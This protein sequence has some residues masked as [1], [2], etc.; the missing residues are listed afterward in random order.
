C[1]GLGKP[2]ASGGSLLRQAARLADRPE[3][4]LEAVDLSGAQMATQML[5][6]P[7]LDYRRR[8]TGKTASWAGAGVA[9]GRRMLATLSGSGR[10]LSATVV[11]GSAAWA[12]GCGLGGTG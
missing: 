2:A 3:T 1:R 5:I 4:R 11:P 9:A 12:R 7:A 10:G 6:C 8:T